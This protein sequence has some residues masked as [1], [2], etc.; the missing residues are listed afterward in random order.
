MNEP[1]QEVPVNPYFLG[2]WFGDGTRCST[3]ISNNHEAE[4]RDFLIQHAAE[5][6]LHPVWHKGLNHATV[7]RTRLA[8]RPIPETTS[9]PVIRPAKRQARQTIIQQRLQAGWTFQ[10]NQKAAEARIWCRPGE[11]REPSQEL[12]TLGGNS[13]SPR[14]RRTGDYMPN[15]GSSFASSLVFDEHSSSL[16]KSIPPNALSELRSDDKFMGIVGDSQIDN[17]DEVSDSNIADNDD[18][19]GNIDLGLVDIT[20]KPNEDD[21][22]EEP[23]EGH[24][25]IRLQ[26][27]CH[28]YGDLQ[29]DEQEQPIDEITM[30]SNTSTTSGVS[31]YAA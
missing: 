9:K 1:K 27:G 8:D 29:D 3:T 17:S 15:L 13:V 19:I 10:P 24:L 18:E 14:R 25:H 28:A 11:Q 6:D 12:P 7:G 4:I 30:H 20:S 16:V 23:K 26:A 2:L 22:E 31:R 21:D 5:L